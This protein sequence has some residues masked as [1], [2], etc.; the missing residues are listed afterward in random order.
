MLNKQ[1]PHP[2]ENNCTLPEMSVAAT[3]RDINAVV[4]HLRNLQLAMQRLCSP[5][6]DFTWQRGD[7]SSSGVGFI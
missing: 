1:V 2:D 4:E 7:T 3:G 6:A 5:S